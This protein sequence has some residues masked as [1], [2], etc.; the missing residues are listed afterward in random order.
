MSMSYVKRHMFTVSGKMLTWALS[1]ILV[2]LA[3]FTLVASAMAVEAK[4]G[5]DVE[6][7]AYPT[8]LK[9]G[10]T[11]M[12]VVD[13]YNTGAGST[14]GTVT[15]TDTLPPGLEAVEAAAMTAFG[16]ISNEGVESYEEQDEQNEIE[17]AKHEYL[18]VNS[19]EQLRVWDCSGTTVVTCDHGPRL[20]WCT[21]SDQAGIRGT[22]RDSR[23]SHRCEWHRRQHGHR[24]RWWRSQRRSRHAG[25]N[26]LCHSWLWRRGIRR[27]A[28]QRR[29]HT[30]RAGRL[31][32]IRSDA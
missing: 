32:P 10:G 21:A 12:L 19:T 24:E 6:S 27:L 8:N 7:R 31:A 1:A 16:T 4:P 23:Q 28:L 26:R 5:W 17:E 13:L 14:N 22:H 11:G 30:G 25:D 15:L 3:S 20:Q 29:W 18:G 9:P 2:A